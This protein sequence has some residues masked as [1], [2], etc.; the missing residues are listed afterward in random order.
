MCNLEDRGLEALG[1]WDD[2]EVVKPISEIVSRYGTYLDEQEQKIAAV[3]AKVRKYSDRQGL[4]DLEVGLRSSAMRKLDKREK[5]YKYSTDSFDLLTN[6]IGN[7]KNR[8]TIEKTL[9]VFSRH[10]SWRAS[11]SGCASR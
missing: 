7:F 4:S 5:F 3:Q 8:K 6:V 1:T 10:P 9:N 2:A 11:N